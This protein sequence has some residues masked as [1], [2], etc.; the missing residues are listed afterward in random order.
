MEFR[1]LGALEVR[2]SGRRVP[3]G[4]GKQRATLAILLLHANQV[5]PTER[6][7]DEL[8]AE[9]PPETARKAVQVYV[10]RMRKAL[11]PDRIRTHDP[12]YVL[13]LAPEELDIHQFE[14]LL[15]EGREL[16]ADGDPEAAGKILRE[17]LALW[18]G[19]PLSDF[20]YEPFAQTEIARLEELHLTG[21]EERIETELALGHGADLVGELEA[22]ATRH[23]FRERLRGLLMLALYQAGRQAEALAAYQD[24]RRVLVEELGIEPSR[25]LQRLERAI[26]RQEPALDVPLAS[27]P[28]IPPREVR[29]TV[30]VVAF[31]FAETADSRGLRQSL[32]ASVSQT[33]SRHGGAMTHSGLRKSL[34]A[35]FGIPALHEDDALR[36]VRA[37]LE[38]AGQELPLQAGIETGEVVVTDGE[39]G[40]EPIG[41]DLVAGAARLRD[42]AGAGEVV[43]SEATRKLVAA[44]LRV[45]PAASGW[46]VLELVP[47]T[48]RERLEGPF[49]GRDG[50]L[51]QLRHILTRAAHERT[52]HLVTVLGSAGIGKSRLVRE[53]ASLI[54]EGAT[55]LTGRCLSY[56]EGITFWPLREI[57]Q[58]ATGEVTGE[59]VRNL[60]EG[61][62]DAGA[63][64][65]LLAA[66]LGLAEPGWSSEEEIFWAVRRLLESLAHERPLVVVLEDLHWAESTFLDLVEHLAEWTHGAPLLLVCTARLELLDERPLWGGGKP[67]VSSLLLESLGPEESEILLEALPGSARL[68][69]PTRTR[70]AGVAEGNPLFL[71]QLVAEGGELSGELPIPPTIEALLAARLDRLGPGE[72]AV[73]ETA[74]VVG[75]EFWTD[76]LS[77]LLPPE[78]RPLSSRH[79]AALVRKQLVRPAHGPQGRAAFRFG[80]ILIQQAAYRSVGMERRADLHES[81]AKW[82]TETGGG[83]VGELDELVGYHLEQASLRLAEMRAS[84]ARVEALADGA[85]ERLA[86]AARKAAT[87][88]DARAAVNLFRRARSLLSSSDQ[89]QATLGVSLADALTSVGDLKNA[90]TL[91]LETQRAAAA[92]GDLRTEWLA[93]IQYAWL[94]D[95]LDPQSWNADEVRRTAQKALAVFEEL[96]DDPGL[97]RAWQL[98][99]YVDWSACHFDAAAKA[100][101]RQMFHARRAGDE[102]AELIAANSL[103]AA[104]YYGPTPAPDAIARIDEL[105]AEV[106]D[107][108][109]EAKALALVPLAGLHTMQGNFEEGRSLYERS[110]AMRRELGLTL[111]MAWATM[112]A[113]E[114]HLLAGDTDGA[115]RELRWGYDTLDQLGEKAARSTLAADFAEALYRQARYE[116]A[117]QV[118]RAAIEAASPEDVASQVMGRA[119]MAKLLGVKGV[120]DEAEQTAR[121]AVALAEQTDDLFTLGQTHMALAEVL[122]LA[123]RREQAIEAF[124]AAAETSERKG[125]VV[126]AERARAQLAELRAPTGSS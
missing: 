79:L 36:A 107:R 47:E 126:T 122:L 66:A 45:E 43:L 93:V 22:L 76:A 98:A 84:S 52:V 11:G 7:I 114:I 23:P 51:A 118:V 60:L 104:L 26:L 78:A 91:L 49:V 102:Q 44:A 125:N 89:R 105:M 8:W 54:D 48:A 53:F 113:R 69:E 70:I 13:E 86:A 120:E 112:N 73:L 123:E 5:V 17:A 95:H 10:T 110:Q 74:S 67:N 121:E 94:R 90:E 3:L 55:V 96:G 24:T 99:G 30:T 71:E 68:S 77:E 15:R 108:A 1:I 41:T 75:K 28:A 115:E 16:R 19:S 61:A 106:D 116:E 100:S 38:L 117:E 103:M 62:D 109:V 42:S 4:A 32:A 37:A 14:R 59:S 80:H 85:S 97:A 21:L 101:E 18:R 81:L 25:A 111:S 20:M 50:D 6:L 119:V 58:E 124:E 56:G 88:G 92:S 9:D 35:V 31:G 29:K 63:V 39:V 33:V 64:A 72:R 65:E 57:V 2:D 34:V 12:G 82:L 87:R 83:P 46:R 40:R 27:E